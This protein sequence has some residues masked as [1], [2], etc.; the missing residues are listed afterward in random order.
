MSE[1][2]PTLM[3]QVQSYWERTPC[4]TDDEIVGA[5]DKMS[6]EWFEAIEEY[7][8]RVEPFIHSMAQ[9]TRH[10]GKR[11]L[12]I[13]VG[14]GTDHLQWARAG[15][16][17]YGLASKLEQVSAES[18]AHPDGYFD[19]VYSWGVIHH[20][21]NP[22]RVF[23]EVHRVLKPGSGQFIGMLYQRPSLTTLRNWLKHAMLRGRPWRS[24]SEVLSEHMESPGTKAYTR[25][26]VKRMLSY[27]REVEVVPLLTVGDTHKLPAAIALR[28]P[29]T[30]GWFLGIRAKR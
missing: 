7:R 29:A 10:R 17:I 23:R 9:F 20:S 14:A 28:L 11:V 16:D 22:E 27:F 21:E 26:E 4:G 12:E 15:A 1:R 6:R 8:Y 24:F 18:L 13:G 2:S 3:A 19:V 5:T 25:S 30:W